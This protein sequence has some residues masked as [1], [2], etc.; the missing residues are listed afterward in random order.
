VGAGEPA[1]AAGDPRGAANRSDH[2]LPVRTALPLKTTQVRLTK[3]P[4]AEPVRVPG[5]MVLPRPV[6]VALPEAVVPL[7]CPE[8]WPR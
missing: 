7:A 6:R 5:P 8:P 3:T 2:G 4:L 1:A